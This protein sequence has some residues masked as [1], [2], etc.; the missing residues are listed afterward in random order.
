MKGDPDAMR[1][2]YLKNGLDKR[3][4]RL[5]HR[6]PRR[7]RK[8]EEEATSRLAERLGGPVIKKGV[9]SPLGTPSCH[10][11]FSAVI[12]ASI[13]AII[14]CIAD[15]LENLGK[16]TSSTCLG[17]LTFGPFFCKINTLL[18]A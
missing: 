3:L 8:R 4:A 6:S 7:E 14:A 17:F 10:C 2:F 13:L 1:L 16:S 9:P 5:N 11:P 18:A 12:Q 15:L